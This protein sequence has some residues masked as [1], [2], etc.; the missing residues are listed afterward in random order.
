VGK[1]GSN[2]QNEDEEELSLRGLDQ[3]R[4]SPHM[5]D[6]FSE[7]FFSL[8]HPSFSIGWL[9]V[10]ERLALGGPGWPG[11]AGLGAKKAEFHDYRRAIGERL[12]KCEWQPAGGRALSRRCGWAGLLKWE[13]EDMREGWSGV[14][15]L[16]TCG[17]RKGGEVQEQE[18]R[19]S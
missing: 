17:R 5:S 18:G 4:H 2:F 11:W 15:L 3:A 19:R 6:P 16:T 9:V 7:G 14:V 8:T 10:E 12:E 13:D 1:K